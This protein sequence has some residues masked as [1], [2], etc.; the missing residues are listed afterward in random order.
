MFSQLSGDLLQL[1][2]VGLQLFLLREIVKSF[3]VQKIIQ[4][5]HRTP[6]KSFLLND[7]NL[8]KQSSEEPLVLSPSNF[9]RPVLVYSFLGWQ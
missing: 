1:A 9:V 6:V 4:E 5:K 8:S 3:N 2:F 7:V